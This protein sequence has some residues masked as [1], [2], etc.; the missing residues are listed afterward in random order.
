MFFFN[1]WGENSHSVD[2]KI[3]AKL[4]QSIKSINGKK[5]SRII[6]YKGRNFQA[7]N[8]FGVC[9]GY[10]ASFILGTPELSPK[11]SQTEYSKYV[12]QQLNPVTIQYLENILQREGGNVGNA[13][14][15]DGINT[16]RNDSPK[17]LK[18]KTKIAS[19][20]S[21]SKSKMNVNMTSPNNTKSNMN[22]NMT[23]PNKSKSLMNVNM[24]SPNKYK[25]NM[26]VNMI[27]PGR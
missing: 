12:E 2:S 3:S 22:V 13:K 8:S 24:I 21:K 4:A 25:S 20:K 7:F 15:A 26:N 17:S 11:M 16:T 5:L 27:S 18:R 1:A 10:A 19:D 23:S 14:N 9:V 6:H